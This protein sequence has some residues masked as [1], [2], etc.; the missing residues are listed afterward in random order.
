MM[1][2][3]RFIMHSTLHNTFDTISSE[4]KRQCIIH[5]L[6]CKQQN[7]I[8]YHARQYNA[9]QYNTFTDKCVR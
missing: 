6:F 3:K 5:S 2:G 4:T 9:M 8:K 1:C 7:K